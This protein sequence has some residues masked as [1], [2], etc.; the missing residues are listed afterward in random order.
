MVACN[1]RQQQRW[2]EGEIDDVRNKNAKEIGANKKERQ[3]AR[4]KDKTD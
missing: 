3:V 2:V 1:K 4:E